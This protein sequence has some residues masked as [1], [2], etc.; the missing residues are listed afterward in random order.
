[1]LMA[2]IDPLQPDKQLHMDVD[3]QENMDKHI[4]RRSSLPRL[5][6]GDPN[7]LPL[8]QKR[9]VY[10]RIVPG[11]QSPG[12][13]NN[14]TMS[15]TNTIT[16]SSNPIPPNPLP[17]QPSKQIISNNLKRP[18]SANS[19]SSK[20]LRTKSPAINALRKEKLDSGKDHVDRKR[21]EARIF[22]S[23]SQLP[24]CCSAASGTSRR[25][26]GSAPPPIKRARTGEETPSLT[27]ESVASV[28]DHRWTPPPDEQLGNC[29]LLLE[30]V[31]T[32]PAG[33]FI[34]WPDIE[35]GKPYECVELHY[36]G[37]GAREC[38]P[39]VTTDKEDN[40]HP[41]LDFM[42]TIQVITRHCIPMKNQVSFG[43]KRKQNETVPNSLLGNILKAYANSDTNLLISSV[44]EYNIALQALRE[45]HTFTLAERSGPAAHEELVVHALEQAYGRVVALHSE[46]LNK[47]ISWTSNVYGEIKHEFVTMLIKEADIKPHHVFLDLGSGIGNVVL[48][49]AAQTLAE[50]FGIEV[51]DN[52]SKLAE[53]QRVEF[54]K[55]MRYYGKPCGKITLKQGNMLE[56]PETIKFVQRADVI[57]VNNYAFTAELNQKI[58][59]LFLDLKDHA[60]VIS[61]KSFIPADRNLTLR[62]MDSIE[63]ILKN[64]EYVFGR[65][66]VSWMSEGGKFYIATRD[67]KWRKEQLDRILAEVPS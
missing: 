59:Q 46:G 66:S 52:P 32:A 1:M 11:R 67:P 37:M 23:L 15:S 19:S 38:F 41:L 51:M 61:L 60:K 3:H 35:P 63:S 43:F 16:P 31:K 10:Y 33:T 34:P 49:V 54:L 48:Q 53:M 13:I 9:V 40:I 20:P 12:V 7:V 22:Y 39:I 62:N 29:E 36:P 21:D 30:H 28:Q 56:D 65:E 4:Q 18:S 64:K 42:S 47:Y 5:A 25:R 8:P 2:P 58:L 27:D 24:A 44:K 6:K 50:C 17:P 14:N 45:Q 55:R 57:L 26:T